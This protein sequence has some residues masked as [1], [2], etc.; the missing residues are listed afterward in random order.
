MS[1]NFDFF[2]FALLDKVSLTNQTIKTWGTLA[3][4]IQALWGRFKKL[5]IRLLMKSMQRHPQTT[6]PALGTGPDKRFAP[7]LECYMN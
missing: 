1:L 3:Q 7:I 4:E 2:F 5:K 6:E